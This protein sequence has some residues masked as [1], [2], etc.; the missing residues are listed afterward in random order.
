MDT[1]EY[2]LCITDDEWGGYNREGEIE[3]GELNH[4]LTPREI[5]EIRR[6][7][8]G[9]LK[10]G[11][12]LHVTTH[13]DHDCYFVIDIVRGT[14]WPKNQNCRVKVSSWLDGELH[15]FYSE[16]FDVS[17]EVKIEIFINELLKEE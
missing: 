2:G 1:I 16:R 8:P 15:D 10:K 13:V 5:E 9:L 4:E 6:V 11:E 14:N 12:S 3:V 17:D 7:L